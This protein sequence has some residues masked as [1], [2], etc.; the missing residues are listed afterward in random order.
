MVEDA[1]ESAMAKDEAS[2]EPADDTMD[3]E[4]AAM[5]TEGAW[6]D[7]A[8]YD[9]DPADVPRVRRCRPVL[10]RLVVPHLPGVHQEPR[11]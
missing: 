11:R 6:I 5:S 7:Q 10:Q 4:D 2:T 1:D 9:A 8:A 3:S